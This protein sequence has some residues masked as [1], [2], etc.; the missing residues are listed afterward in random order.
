MCYNIFGIFT[1]IKER[2]NTMK[3]KDLLGKMGTLVI[4]AVMA[5]TTMTAT[6]APASAY[7]IEYGNERH[8]ELTVDGSPTLFIVSGDGT[9]YLTS[10]ECYRED[11]MLLLYHQDNTCNPEK[12]LKEGWYNAYKVNGKKI[13]TYDQ[14]FKLPSYLPLAEEGWDNGPLRIMDNVKSICASY[15]SYYTDFC[16]IKKDNS[17]WYVHT[18]KPLSKP[19]NVENLKFSQIKVADNISDAILSSYYIYAITQNKELVK[20]DSKTNKAHKITGFDKPKTLLTNVRQVAFHSNQTYYEHFAAVKT[21]NTLWE[22]GTG[23]YANGQHNT[24]GK[25]S[26]VKTYQNVK[27]VMLYKGD[28]ANSMDSGAFVG[29]DGKVYAW[30]KK[31]KYYDRTSG[32]VYKEYGKTPTRIIKSGIDKC[33]SNE[34]TDIYLSAKGKMYLSGDNFM[35]QIAGCADKYSENLVKQM[36]NVT[37]ITS[38]NGMWAALKKDGSVWF[39]GNNMFKGTDR[40]TS[41]PIKVLTGMNSKDGS[42]NVIN[43]FNIKFEW[44]GFSDAKVYT[45]K[46]MTD[47]TGK[48]WDY[49]SHSTNTRNYAYVT[50]PGTYTLKVIVRGGKHDGETFDV[51]ATTY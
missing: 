21:D 5:V 1:A 10:F 24:E 33:V 44:K 19:T 2:R 27:S 25:A 14:L 26:P 37:E 38:R 17:L 32:N 8:I 15:D 43:H 3:I 13:T 42:I 11:K 9:L 51:T 7:S 22:W 50:K 4:A 18:E 30:G 29:T 31:F 48:R 45:L 23:S 12:A 47:G 40:S 36:S 6:A 28:F 16:V 35:G 46:G 41:K 49:S 39:C 34:R 20:F